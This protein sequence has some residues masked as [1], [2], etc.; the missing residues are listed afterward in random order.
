MCGTCDELKAK[1]EH[2]RKIMS[3]AGD[4]LTI[5]RIKELIHDYE[6]ELL[7]VDCEDKR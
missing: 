2:T 3:A 4:T 7:A 1:I 6:K 5:E